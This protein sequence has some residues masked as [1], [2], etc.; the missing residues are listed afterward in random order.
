MNG[1]LGI[2]FTTAGIGILM[3][4]ALLGVLI[5]ILVGIS[6]ALKGIN[7]LRSERKNKEEIKAI[8]PK[9]ETNDEE[10]IAVITAAI[11][12]YTSQNNVKKCDFKVK[13]LR[14]L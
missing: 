6:A 8:E 4:F 14:R 10:L 1:N 2:A 9:E 7:R 12:Q 5:L 3:V 13:N 11:T